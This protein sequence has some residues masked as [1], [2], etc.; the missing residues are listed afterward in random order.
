LCISVSVICIFIYRNLTGCHIAP[1]KQALR[2]VRFK[3]TPETII[4]R[5]PCHTSVLLGA[6]PHT[7]PYGSKAAV[8]HQKICCVCAGERV[9]P[10]S[11]IFRD[12]TNAKYGGAW[13]DKDQKT[14]GVPTP[15]WKS[16]KV[17]DF[18]LEN[19]KTWKVLENHF[20]P[21]VVLENIPESRTFFL[22]DQMENEQQ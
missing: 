18:F 20:G 2:P 12:Q 4:K 16:W 1:W 3:F 17:L 21:A 11:R 13:P 10:T 8:S 14:N 19:S 5:C 22:V 9:E 6:V 7:W 15:P